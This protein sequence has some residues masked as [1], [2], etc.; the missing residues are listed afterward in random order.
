M[1]YSKICHSDSF[2]YKVTFFLPECCNKGLCFP[3]S[4]CSGRFWWKEMYQ[5]QKYPFNS[6]KNWLKYKESQVSVSKLPQAE[7][8]GEFGH[9][10]VLNPDLIPHSEN[11]KFQLGYLHNAVYK[12]KFQ[13]HIT[14][15]KIELYKFCNYNT[16]A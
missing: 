11:I 1:N 3:K 12:I 13:V 4:E 7:V 6:T 5:F 15:G 2:T 14:I 9:Y 8:R 16:L 10:D